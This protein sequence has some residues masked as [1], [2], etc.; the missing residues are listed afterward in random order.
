MS[1]VTLTIDRALLDSMEGETLR[2]YSATSVLGISES[3]DERLSFAKRNLKFMLLE[4]GSHLIA[5]G[6]YTSDTFLDAMVTADS[7]ELLETLLAYNF[8]YLLFQDAA[9][10][11]RGRGQQKYEFYY[12]EFLKGL[13]MSVRILLAKL[14]PP[15]QGR[16]RRFV[17]VFG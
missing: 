9:I 12:G 10:N 1:W 4:A 5:D 15:K 16:N 11:T 13:Q 3:D 17:G 2:N 6:S 7:D 14:T 8:L